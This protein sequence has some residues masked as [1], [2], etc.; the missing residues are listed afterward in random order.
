MNRATSGGRARLS[1]HLKYVRGMCSNA[2]L[3]RVVQDT[4][5]GR[6]VLQRWSDSRVDLRVDSKHSRGKNHGKLFALGVHGVRRLQMWPRHLL[7]TGYPAS[8]PDHYTRFAVLQGMGMLFGSAGG[9]ELESSTL[10]KCFTQNCSS[11]NTNHASSDRVGQRGA[12]AVRDDKLGT[13]S[14][15]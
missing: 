8:V 12:P 4:Q 10:S 1:K 9:G 5:L 13:L 11:G 6:V 14:I 7:P 3:N 15:L 2:G